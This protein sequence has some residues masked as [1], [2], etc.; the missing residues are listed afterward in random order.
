[1]N[2][3][4]Q[5]V[6]FSFGSICLGSLFIGPAQFLRHIAMYIRPS[7]EEAAIQVFVVFQ[8]IIVSFIDLVCV[9]FNKWAFSYVGKTSYLFK[10]EKFIERMYIYIIHT[11]LIFF[12]HRNIWL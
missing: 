9:K 3:F 11:L 4:V 10:Y 1:M 6:R 8:D 5:V 2:T 7:K 12:M